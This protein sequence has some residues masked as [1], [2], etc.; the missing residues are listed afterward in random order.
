MSSG[1]RTDPRNMSESTKVSCALRMARSV[2]LPSL[3]RRSVICQP[4]PSAENSAV[5]FQAL[6]GRMRLQKS[7]GFFVQTVA[8]VCL[9]MRSQ[10]KADL[11]PILGGGGVMRY[12]TPN[13]PD[14]PVVECLQVCR[15]QDSL[16]PQLGVVCAREPGQE[17]PTDGKAT[18]VTRRHRRNRL[19][20]RLLAA[21]VVA[22]FVASSLRACVALFQSLHLPQ[23]VGAPC[24]RALGTRP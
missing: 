15:S 3:P 16:W 17:R 9:N 22:V 12:G 7:T 2:A 4:S 18:A 20:R 21:A 11:H 6:F 23:P 8:F 10:E 19:I 1:I 13:L 24:H 5:P 14:V